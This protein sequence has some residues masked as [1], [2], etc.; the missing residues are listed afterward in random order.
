MVAVFLVPIV[1]SACSSS[2]AGS[3]SSTS[4][5]RFF[6]DLPVEVKRADQRTQEGYRYALVESDL[7][8]AIPCYC[9]CVAIAHKSNEDCYVSGYND[10][11]QPQFDLHALG[12]DVCVDITQDAVRMKSEGI[13]VASLRDN[14]S[15]IYSRYGPPTMP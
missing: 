1:L 7:L 13:S 5:G 6:T 8:A 11:G 10:Q 14:L 3:M 2:Q 9:G 12:C 4:D 15:R